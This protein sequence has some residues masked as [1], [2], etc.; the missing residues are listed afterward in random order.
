MLY[1]TR[2]A[3][4]KTLRGDVNERGTAADLDDEQVDME[5]Y[6]AQAQIDS[7]LRNKYNVPFDPVP[8][9][10]G[11]IARDIA[12]YLCDLNYRKSREYGSDNYPIIRRHDRARE[13]LEWLRH[14]IITVDY[15]T[16]ASYTAKSGVFHAYEDRLMTESDV[17]GWSS[18]HW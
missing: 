14:G 17:F 15:P 5:I 4:R 9:L 2:D 3:V 8:V 7:A 18:T 16:S 6:N 12:A 13:L 10:I 1:T 11:N